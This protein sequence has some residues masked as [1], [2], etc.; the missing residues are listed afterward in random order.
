MSRPR[1]R[2]TEGRARNARPRDTAGRPLAKGAAG[3][4]RVPDELRLAPAEALLQAQ[5]LL[6][7]GRPF[8]AHEVF[9][10]TWKATRGPERA[11]WQGL[12]Q[13]AVGLTHAQRG[14]V[15]GA[16]A[17]LRRGVERLAPF[18][19]HPPHRIDVAGLLDHAT[20]LAARIDTSGTTATTTESDLRPRLRRDEGGQAPVDQH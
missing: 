16:V 7:A 14:N 6:D 17:L 1:D 4:A 5:R 11:L 3:V 18:A 15:T 9:E 19:P 8:H 20:A 12:A 10:G 2:D 13:L